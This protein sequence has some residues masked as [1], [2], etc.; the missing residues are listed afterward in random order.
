MLS[1]EEAS[2]I[3]I[4]AARVLGEGRGKSW[5][6]YLERWNQVVQQVE[7]GYD[8]TIYDYTNDLDIRSRLESILDQT[9]RGSAKDKLA[10]MIEAIDERFLNATYE[11]AIPLARGHSLD[12]WWWNRAPQKAGPELERD[13]RA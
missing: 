12:E 3:E 4:A 13:L 10:R 9:S 6:E 2:A 8:F 7:Q 11:R 5:P 1:P